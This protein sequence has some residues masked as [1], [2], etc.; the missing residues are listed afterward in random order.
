MLDVRYFRIYQ[1]STGCLVFD[2]VILPTLSRLR[3]YICFMYICCIF[4]R[5]LNTLI[6]RCCVR[7]TMPQAKPILCPFYSVTYLRDEYAEDANTLTPFVC[8]IRNIVGMGKWLQSD[9]G[10]RIRRWGTDEGSV[11][12]DISVSHSQLSSVPFFPYY[13]LPV[14]F[15]TLSTLSIKFLAESFFLC[16][17]FGEVFSRSAA[18]LRCRPNSVSVLSLLLFAS[19][20]KRNLS[21]KWWQ[22]EKE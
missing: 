3:E 20:L 5:C 1:F 2:L 13:T 6:R 14:L 19:G 9:L 15:Q 4:A 7:R 18:L 12:A 17:L 21:L 10:F 22:A 11:A 16:S 8:Y